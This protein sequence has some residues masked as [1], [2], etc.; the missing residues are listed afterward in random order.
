MIY[1]I[2]IAVTR[3][4]I[5]ICEVQS[6]NSKPVNAQKINVNGSTHIHS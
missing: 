2:G 4:H 6:D 5:A 1:N 3:I